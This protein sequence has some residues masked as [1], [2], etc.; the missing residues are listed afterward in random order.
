MIVLVV[1]FEVKEGKKEAFMDVIG[2]L[3]E[4]SQNEAG[5]IEYDLFADMEKPNAFVLLEKWKDQDALDFHKTT[6]HYT[7]NLDAIGALCSEV[8]INQ[9]VPV[10]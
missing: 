8:T 5:N 6:D 10:G 4:G 2:R 7:G 1:N 3:I 9:F